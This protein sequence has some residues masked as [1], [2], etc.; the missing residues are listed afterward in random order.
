MGKHI[1][2][3]IP[4]FPISRHPLWTLCYHYRVRQSFVHAV[5]FP[6]AGPTQCQCNKL[7]FINLF[8]VNMCILY[9]V[10]DSD[11]KSH[12]F[13]IKT[14]FKKKK[15]IPIFFLPFAV[16]Q[17]CRGVSKLAT[18]SRSSS[19]LISSRNL[20]RRIQIVVRSY[21]ASFTVSRSLSDSNQV[22]L[23]AKSLK[24]AAGTAQQLLWLY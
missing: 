23:M 18:M 16:T 14:A 11:V 22:N 19:S 20:T 2:I 4:F 21:F 1:Q 6:M 12:N 5:H 3:Q 15:I 24:T 13:M 9:R 10:S 7:I 8:F 17:T